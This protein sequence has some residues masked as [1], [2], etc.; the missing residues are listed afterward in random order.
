MLRFRASALRLI[1]L[2]N[3]GLRI[4]FVQKKSCA[5]GNLRL[6]VPESE[7]LRINILKKDSA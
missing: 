4:F 2:R 1:E 7:S 3:C 5:D 6:K